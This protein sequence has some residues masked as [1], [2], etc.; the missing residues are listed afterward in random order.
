MRLYIKR[1]KKGFKSYGYLVHKLTWYGA[2]IRKTL[3]YAIFKKV[4]N[5]VSLTETGPEVYVA[6]M[7]TVILYYY[8][9]L[10]DTLNH[11]K[12]LKLRDRPWENVAYL[13]AE[14]LVYYD[15]FDSDG[16]FK[17][18]PFGYITC[19]FERILIILYY[20]YEKLRNIRRLRSLLRNLMCVT[21][22]TCD[23]SRSLPMGNLFQRLWV[24]TATLLAQSGGKLLTSR[25]IL[26]M[27]RCLWG[28]TLGKL[29]SQS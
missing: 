14:V 8:D 5:L 13:C 6:T 16:I 24:N 19:I 4:L 2:Y 1:L 18:N 22:I 17:T 15:Q 23:L 25:K 29:K 21:R 10:G 11:L 20:I 28:F 9:Y 26:K 3:S 12:C 7:T 27:R